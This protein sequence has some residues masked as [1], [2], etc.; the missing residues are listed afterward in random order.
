MM[1]PGL[2]APA[3]AAACR[4]ASIL[5]RHWPMIDRNSGYLPMF[6]I[7]ADQLNM[8]VLSV[9]DSMCKDSCFFGF[10]PKIDQSTQTFN[11]TGGS[12]VAVASRETYGTGVSF[13]GIRTLIIVDIPE[14][15]TTY[16]QNVGRVMRSC[17]Y[18]NL[19]SNERKVELVMFAAELYKGKTKTADDFY[20]KKLKT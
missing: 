11:K 6:Q 3:F 2:R 1:P 7:L 12:S 18:S 8:K 14:N 20:L 9:N 16:L 13:L 5:R 10:A 4:N 15:V 17:G 19:P